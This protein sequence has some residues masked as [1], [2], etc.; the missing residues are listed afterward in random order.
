MF[1][2][3]FLAVVSLLV[4]GMLGLV[5]RH[6]SRKSK[7]RAVLRLRQTRTPPDPRAFAEKCVRRFERK[8]SKYPK[9]AEYTVIL[10]FANRWL[11]LL[12]RPNVSIEDAVTFEREVE[13]TTSEVCGHVGHAWYEL[14]GAIKVWS[15][16]VRGWV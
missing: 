7:P 4:I 2:W 13:H 3:W 12:N 1:S 8:A 16:K 10:R 14:E 15:R 11:E 5:L 6:R 9:D